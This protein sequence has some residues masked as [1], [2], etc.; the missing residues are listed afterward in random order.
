MGKHETVDYDAEMKADY[1]HKEL[2]EDGF[3]PK[4]TD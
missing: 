2:S 1:V 4:H 3:T